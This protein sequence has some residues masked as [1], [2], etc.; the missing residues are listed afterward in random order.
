MTYRNRKL[1]DLA[2]EAPCFVNI[3]KP[4]GNDPSVPAH[5]DMLKHGRGVG[6]KSGDQFAVSCC[7]NCHAKFTREFLGRDQYAEIWLQA[8]ERFLTWMFENEKVKVTG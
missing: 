4:C 2:H 7:P 8:H 1:L 5:S 3:A 6:H